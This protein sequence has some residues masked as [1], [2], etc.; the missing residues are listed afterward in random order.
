MEIVEHSTQ[1]EPKSKKSKIFQEEVKQGPSSL[2]KGT[3]VDVN[4]GN[5]EV[6][7]AQD[8]RRSD[9]EACSLAGEGGEDVSVQPDD[10]KVKEVNDSHSLA[11]VSS[12]SLAG[13]KLLVLDLN[14]LLAD[15]VSSPSKDYAS[16]I[17]IGRKAIFKRPFCDDFLKFCFEKFQ[18]GIWSSRTQRNVERITDYLLG[19]M[20]SRLLFCWDMSQCAKSRVGSLENR[21][22]YVVFKELKR[23]WEKQDP[24][25]PWKQG[26]YNETNT[27]LI[28]DSPYKA[29]LNPLHTAI[30]PHSFDYHNKTDTSLGEGGDL[31]LYLERL[32]EADNVQE[33]IKEH[34]FG[35]EPITETS[36]SW[37][38]YRQII[39]TLHW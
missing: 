12:A 3:V 6:P 32:A 21:F 4:R 9:N 38:F 7:L 33:F 5:G 19:D 37:E 10:A 24:D 22:K 14:G 28:D 15:I 29:L 13:K 31:R 27:I 2:M 26:A 18:V 25:L 11:K 17:T 39:G 8:E 23:L 34:P 1:E 16:D 35:Q 36:G 20:K 30:F